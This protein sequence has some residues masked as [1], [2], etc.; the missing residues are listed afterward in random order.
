[1]TKVAGRLH[2]MS[3]AIND[4]ELAIGPIVD[5]VKLMETANDK[6]VVKI[7]LGRLRQIVNC[8]PALNKIVNDP[9][10]TCRG[11]SDD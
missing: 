6:V 11:R 4:A 2:Q 8:Y 10:F 7:S 5:L 1:M 9:K 3:L